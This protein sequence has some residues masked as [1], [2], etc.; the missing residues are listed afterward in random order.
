MV[1]QSIGDKSHH[2]Q[3]VFV[4]LLLLVL[5]RPSL[6]AQ[7]TPPPQAPEIAPASDDA[8]NAMQLFLLPEGVTASVFAAEPDVANPVAIDVDPLGRVFVCESFRQ[9]RG[10]ED[11]RNHPEWLHD[12]LA[13][14]TVS[15]R[16]AYIRK[17]LGDRAIEYTYHDDR[18]RLL[19]DS[20]ADGHAD[21]SHV[22]AQGFN[23]IEEGTGAGVLVHNGHTYFTC[24]PRLWRLNDDDGD[25]I[26]DARTV[27]HEGFGVRFAFRGHDLHGLIIGPDGR[28]YFSIGDRGYHVT[29][30]VSDPESGAVFRCE[31]DG[32]NLEVVATGLRNPQE[33]VFDD[34][35]NLFTGDNNSDSG[36]KARLVYVVEGSDSGWRMAFQYLADRGPFNREN[37]WHPYDPQTTPAYIV[38][39]I[40]NF[41]DGPSGFAFYPGTGFS[42]HMNGRFL[43]C[44]FRGQ[45]TGSGIKTFRLQSSGAFF[46]IVDEE[47]T[48]WNILA[49]DCCFGPD[50]R[51]Y[52]SDWVHGWQ[53]IGK[54]RVYALQD[55]GRNVDLTAETQSIL[56]RGLENEP[57]ERLVEL[58]RHA[59]RRVRQASQF[60]L[61]RR[62]SRQSLIEALQNGG[63]TLTRVHALWGL[64]Q[65][66]R[67]KHPV[68]ESERANLETLV[69][70][71][72][73]DRDVEIVAQA[74][75][76]CGELAAHGH[77]P[78]RVLAG[79]RPIEQALQS[80]CVNANPRVVFFAVSSLGKCTPYQRETA[81][82]V[83]C[84]TLV[85]N[86]DR[87]PLIRHAAIMALTNI[88]KHTPDR[89]ELFQRD[90]VQQPFRLAAAHASDSVRLAAVVA[91]RK[92]AQFNRGHVQELEA[93]L[94][95]QL[96]TDASPRV[97]LESARAVHDVPIESL[98]DELAQ[99]DVEKQLSD[100]LARRFLNANYRLGRGQDLHRV[101]S[102]IE[103]PGQL[104]DRRVEA[105]KLLGSW[106]SPDPLDR[107]LGMWRPVKNQD[108]MDSRDAVAKLFANMHIFDPPVADEILAVAVEQ[109][110]PGVEEA[111]VDIFQNAAL[112]PQPRSLALS[113]L[114]KLKFSG[115]DSYIK[116]ALQSDHPLLRI[117]AIQAWF[118]ADPRAT[119]EHLER[120]AASDDRRERQIALR[121]MGQ[122]DDDRSAQWLRSEARDMDT[123]P[124]DSRLDLM[125]A[126]ERR[127]EGDLRMMA[128]NWSKGVKNKFGHLAYAVSIEGGD[129]MNGSDIFFNRGS[130]S[131]LRCHKINGSGGD[132]G[133]ELSDVGSQ[134]DRRY[135][136]ESLV[137]PNKT[138]TENF[139]TVVVLDINGN[140]HIGVPKSSDAEKLAIMT[141][142]AEL[143]TIPQ[144]DIDEMRRGQSAM[145]DD[146]TKH[147]T[148]E[149]IR[150]LIEFLAQQK[151]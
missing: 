45:S 69:L 57:V 68:S 53:G 32:S 107:V 111:L 122:L 38:P 112:G 25:G 35:G 15:D 58:L 24:I 97:R 92:L 1:E 110:L 31:L 67:N 36:D 61:V 146:V 145:P 132:V 5:N 52:V 87:D 150:D 44:D 43:L 105:V 130:V 127:P 48:F 114:V 151:K 46:E 54:G 148:L 7:Q 101:V 65:L 86:A 80:L 104:L 73:N 144:A 37:I 120:A 143:V 11:N 115:I 2:L 94:L 40:D 141:A 21:Q 138:I 47:N 50:G 136:V 62:E 66:F 71:C 102:F 84:Q 72:L 12:D 119:I 63:A 126:V 49:T 42:Q 123:H 98:M 95:A 121:L 91:I 29:D 26:S 96:L 60:E 142:D 83:V 82:Q 8:T 27:V 140:T 90:G 79:S 100:P 39:P 131:C 135:L 33:L 23:S 99:M 93:D 89:T 137:E 9:E 51:L 117:T 85:N 88:L 124:P 4:V 64:G 41:A 108:R 125:R 109:Q 77:S 81:I 10:I 75:K 55:S 30:R 34:F 113:R 134:R 118:E 129:P 76:L 28:L 70:D 19:V 128:K 13:A 6:A 16:I 78:V 116:A 59:D 18:I 17:H 3:T 139:E 22:F 106:T 149:E 14:K 147:L 20:D 103:D 133:P 74:A 56:K